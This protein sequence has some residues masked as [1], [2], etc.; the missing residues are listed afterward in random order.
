MRE[1]IYIPKSVI[2]NDITLKVLVNKCLVG[3]DSANGMP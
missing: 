3:L 2:V 1:K